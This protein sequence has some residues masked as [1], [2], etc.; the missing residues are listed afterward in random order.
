MSK[1]TLPQSKWQAGSLAVVLLLGIAAYLRFWMLGDAPFR[2]DTM[3]FYKLALMNQNILD[4]WRDPPWLNQ[5]PLNET[6]PLLLVKLGLPATP[7]VVRLPF[8]VMGLLAVFFVWRFARVQFGRE[9]GWIVLAWATFNPYQLYF[10]RMAYH[11]AGAI[12]WSAALLGV[13]WHL[14]MALR[15]Q[16]NPRLLHWCLWLLAATATGYMHMSTWIVIAVQ[17]V[18]LFVLAMRVDKAVRKQV[19]VT[20]LAVGSMLALLISRWLWRAI[21]M[22][23]DGTEQLG[24]EAASEYFRLFP[25]YFAGQN[26]WAL[27]AL[28]LACGLSIWALFTP[29]P[30][31]K[32]EYRLLCVVALVH[33][34]VAFIYITI[35]GG[36]LAKIS[37]FSALWPYLIVPLGV[38]VARACGHIARNRPAS[39]LAFIGG[40]IALYAGLTSIP[41]WAIVTL[42]G[43]ATPFYQINDWI[44]ENLPTGTPILTDRWFEPW[45]ELAIHNAAGIAYTFTVPDEPIDNY[46]AL[47]WPHTAARFFERHPTA[48][49][50]QLTPRR[51]ERQLGRWTFPETHFARSAMIVNEPAMTLRRWQVYPEDFSEA[52]DRVAVRIFHNTPEDLI[53]R[54]RT[55]GKTTVWWPDGGWTFVK[56]W[57]PVAGWPEQMMQALWIQA[58]AYNQD[59]RTFRNLGE[60][61]QLPQAELARFFE[62]GRWADFRQTSPASAIVLYNVTPEPVDVQLAVAAFS[63]STVRLQLAGHTLLFPPNLLTE[64]RVPLRLPPGARNLTLHTSATHPLLVINI[65]VE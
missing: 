47:Q 50:L 42:A 21:R 57:Q 38:G 49:F 51:Y 41:A 11:Y 39:R 9:A 37:Y 22:V 26:P 65:R 61:N 45:N 13:F 7:W 32:S 29:E 64:H 25:A 35:I 43:K 58:G 53:Q 28:G 44:Q 1:T 31:R 20:L 48:A 6:L 63:S 15:R 36:G 55:A 27:L 46:L 40:A 10:S 12:C 56:P 30:Q 24:E 34:T 17:A 23:L 8:A 2:S 60:L 18:W 52:N 59:G 3:E 4:F 19:I 5:I 33:W 16:E 54:A 14:L 62:M